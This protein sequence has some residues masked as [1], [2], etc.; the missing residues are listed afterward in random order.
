MVYRNDV[1]A[2][3]ARHAALA[4]EVADK[5]RDRDEIAGMLAAARARDER[6]RELLERPARRRRH[7]RAAV[8]AA[9]AGLAVIAGIGTYR[10][11]HPKRDRFAPV[12]AK[13]QEF[14]DRM[15]AC[16]TKDCA[17]HVSDDLTKWGQEMAQHALKEDKPDE[18]V[19]KQ[20]TTVVERFANCMTKTMMVQ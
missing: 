8:I 12:M 10:L 1:E 16:K 18:A 14:A 17:Q 13:M 7:R 5:T 20:F 6:E 4:A 19:V 3:E 15:C 9:L 2:L 11:T